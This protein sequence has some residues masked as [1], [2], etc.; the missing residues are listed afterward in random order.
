[1][2]KIAACFGFVITCLLLLSCSKD[3]DSDVVLNTSA[4]QDQTQPARSGFN[5]YFG[6]IG[7][8]SQQISGYGMGVSFY[9]A[10]WSLVDNPIYWLQIGLSGTWILPDNSDNTSTPLCPEGTR[11]REWP[12]RGPTWETVFQTL[13][14]GLG[15]WRGNKFRYGPPK[16]SMNA[17]PQCYD[18]EVASPGWSF[19]YDDQALDD[20]L[21][22]IAQ[23]SNRLLIPPDALT[24]EGEPDGEFMSYAYMA[25]PFTDAYNNG[26]VE[27]GDQS[28]TAFINTENFK[29]PIAF[30][31]PETWA[32]LS[33][34]YPLI[35]GRGLDARPGIINGG[36]MEIN[37][38]PHFEAT[39]SDGTQYIKVPKLNFPVNQDRKAPLVQDLKYYN[40]L[41]LYNEILN[42]R[43]NDVP[44]QGSFISGMISPT[45][46]YNPPF[47]DVY[48]RQIANLGSIFSSYVEDGV[49]GLSWEQSN[50]DPG[51]FP[52]Y[53]RRDGN[54]MI[55]VK[56]VD[57][58]EET[59][60]LEA[61]FST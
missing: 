23:L 15:Y 16:F 4:P 37:T 36:A 6:Y 5:G 1:M 12:E 7:Y 52:E 18:Y 8:G 10:A 58:P 9:T 61:T 45:L 60:L 30:Y 53:F 48:D 47:I 25:L 28:W 43:E 35:E 39:S 26:I 50:F 57:I 22:G 31:L 42:W 44:S 34:R 40:R 55:P 46:T 41:T 33:E 3:S 20:N 2:K 38:V 19:F 11:A 56:A 14:G 29:G 27:V 17:T 24:F 21:L 54:Q 13:E 59:E 51:S 49:F 32:K